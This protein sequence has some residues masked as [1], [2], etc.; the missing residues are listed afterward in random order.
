M[1][2]AAGVAEQQGK[3]ACVVTGKS[4]VHCYKVTCD[5]YPQFYL[6]PLECT[7]FLFCLMWN[8]VHFSNLKYTMELP[9]VDWYA[10]RF[11]R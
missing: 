10:S 6:N 2:Y 7:C 3:F 8:R 5:I 11:A 4:T 1:S 9:L